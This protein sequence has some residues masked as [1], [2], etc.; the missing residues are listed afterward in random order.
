MSDDGAAKARIEAITRQMF[1][2]AGMS[3]SDM[4]RQV[5]DLAD[6]MRPI[7]RVI[8]PDASSTAAGVLKPDKKGTDMS[9]DEYLITEPREIR[10]RLNE[11][12]RGRSFY[13]DRRISGVDALVRN[14]NMM[15]EMQGLSG[16]D[17]YTVMAWHLMHM[18]AKLEAVALEQA[19]LAPP[20][21]IQI[22][23]VTK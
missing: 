7:R 9:D 21:P 18:A 11:M 14:V 6:P 10:Q 20:R 22:N 2:I 3:L 5:M 12:G 4:H 19:M 13:D 16:E 1:E 17:R 8:Q 23:T 15:A